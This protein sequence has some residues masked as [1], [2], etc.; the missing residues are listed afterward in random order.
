MTARILGI[1]S[2]CDETAAAVVVDGV[3]ILSSVVASQVEIHRKYGGV[4]PELAS[5]E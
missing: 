5:R 4:G 2:S 3:T 1:E